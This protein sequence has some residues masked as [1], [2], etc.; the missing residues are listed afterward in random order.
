VPVGD[1]LLADVPAQTDLHALVQRGEV[2]QPLIE[3]F[4]L[5]ALTVDLLDATS[6]LSGLALDRRGELGQLARLD[7]PTVA[8]DSRQGVRMPALRLPQGLPASHEPLSERAHPR[9][10]S[11]RLLRGEVALGHGSTILPFVSAGQR[12]RQARAPV[13]QLELR[14]A[15]SPAL[16]LFLWSRLAIWAAALLAFTWF[17]PNRHPS[18]DRWDNAFFHDLGWL[19]DVWARWDSGWFLRI[20]EGG[21]A[22]APEQAPAFFPL[23]PGLVAG[24][25][26]VLGGHYVLAGI[27]VS[28]AATL[29]AFVL[30]HRLAEPWLGADGARR[31]VLY[32]ALFPLSLFLQAVYSEALFLALA[33]AAFLLAERA[34]W[35]PA[36]ALAGLALLTRP[37]AVALLPALA[38]LA[39]RDPRRTR[40]LASLGLAP[41]LF[42]LYPLFLWLQLGDPLA[43]AR[44]QDVWNRELSPL[45]PLGGV[46]E[47]LRAVV[48]A[49]VP[50]GAEPLHAYA[51]NAESLVF[52][53]LYVGL[54][55]VAW[56]RFGAPYGLFAA[57]S[58]AVPLA[59]P[60]ERWPLLSL[61]RFGLVV[62]PF[63]L[64]LAVLGGR[65]RL[66]AAIAGVSALFLGVA[67]VRWTL[68][69]WV[70]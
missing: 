7:A 59:L 70:A 18:A 52:L 1:L 57:L 27:L 51:V 32:L 22:A 12:V 65:P 17:E 61:P 33:L 69:Q 53:V 60:S 56:R 4:H 66:H 24:L 34:R 13:E 5:R 42:T 21:Y 10:R 62:F 35:L 49:D 15:P 67:V 6:D 30:L 58:L 38:L 48:S 31:A 28:L 36:A 45:G 64:A 63:F 23:Y 47:G 20:A 26:R 46:W 2:H 41:A 37:A 8:C 39:W 44:A 68:W 3:V 43:F 16:E 25:G 40:A 54:T 55:V 29:A 50:L 11:V 14:P 9:K 19:T